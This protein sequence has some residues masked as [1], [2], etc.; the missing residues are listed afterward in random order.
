[1]ASHHFYDSLIA[2]QHEIRLLQLAPGEVGDTII[3]NLPKV[4]LDDRP[5]YE[6][7][8]YAW[9]KAEDAKPIQVCKESFRA[10]HN[11]EEALRKLQLPID[12]RKVLIDAICITQPDT[13]KRTIQVQFIGLISQ[14]VLLNIWSRIQILENIRK[15]A[16]AFEAGTMRE[17]SSTIVSERHRQATN[18]RDYVFGMFGLLPGYESIVDYALSESQFFIRSVTEDIQ[19]TE[20]LDIPSEVIV[21]DGTPAQD[22]HLEI[23][24]SLLPNWKQLYYPYYLN[25]VAYRHKL[26][27]LDNSY[28]GQLTTINFHDDH[29]LGLQGIVCNQ[30]VAIGSKSSAFSIMAKDLATIIIPSREG[31]DATEMT[32]AYPNKYGPSQTYMDHTIRLKCADVGPLVSERSLV[33]AT[34]KGLGHVRE[35]SSVQKVDEVTN[36]ITSNRRLMRTAV[37]LIGFIPMTARRLNTGKNARSCCSVM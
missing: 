24:P 17:F 36:T 18:P 34:N 35:K 3:C 25:D 19:R 27:Y 15:Q 16:E 30:N 6:T 21:P 12:F 4:S 1:M 26:Q 11:L 31:D 7:F 14:T 20:N 13:T 8:S 23:L 28:G 5:D 32:W 29:C 37:G 9:G 33:K 10:N 2:T 22:N